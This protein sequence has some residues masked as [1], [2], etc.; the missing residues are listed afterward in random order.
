MILGKVLGA[1]FGFLFLHN[2]FGILLGFLIGHL[3]DKGLKTKDFHF[4]GYSF[5]F[6]GDPR[7]TNQA[8]FKSAFLVMGYLAKADGRVSQSEIQ[9]ARNI[10]GHLGLNESEVQQAIALFN[11]GKEQQFDL[12]QTLDELIK[13][14]HRHPGILQYFLEIQILSAMADGVLDPIERRVLGEIAGRFGISDFILE[15]LISQ[16]YAEQS[17]ARGGR[18]QRGYAPQSAVDELGAAYTLLGVTKTTPV[19]EIKKAYRKLM[20]Q[21]HPDKLIAKGL[22]ENMIKMA[23]EKTQAIQK[24]YELIG[25]DRGF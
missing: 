20:S 7:A 9:M 5:H 23:T 25:K 14:C 13:A 18:Q 21:H 6:G 19:N 12:N 4:H 1:L 16:F 10:M 2:F 24:A 17:F 22:P 15:R 11:R 3:F 8:F